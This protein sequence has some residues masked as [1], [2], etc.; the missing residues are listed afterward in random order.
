MAKGKHVTYH[1]GDY[2]IT[3]LEQ[4]ARYSIRVRRPPDDT[5]TKW[6]YSKSRRVEAKN[7]AEAVACCVKYAQELDGGM[8]DVP[9]TL[10]D[11]AKTF[12]ENREML[13]KVSPL[14]LAR[15]KI[16]IDRIVR[17]LGKRDLVDLSA[18]IIE[19]AYVEMTKDGVSKDAIH[20]CHMKLKQMMRKAYNTG[21]IK[22]NPCD[23]VEGITR[24]KQDPVKKKEK[25]ITRDEAIDLAHELENEEKTGKVV[26]V[27]LAL[28]TGIRRGEAL[29]LMWKDVDL[30][31]KRLHV[32]RQYGREKTLKPPKTEKSRR[33]IAIDTGT[34]SF[35]SKWKV[36]QATE[37]K[38]SLLQTGDTPVC[39]NELGGFTDPDDLS[40][41]RRG[42]YVRLGLA[43]YEKE[44]KWTDSRG[45][46]RVRHS[47]YVGPNFHALRHAQASLLVAG[48]VDPKTVQERL[49]H[50]RITTTLE[51]YADAEEENDVK[52]AEYINGLF[53]DR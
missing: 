4:G 47:G 12:Q 45:I 15:D 7:K 36:Q 19:K 50:E 11:Y 48:G 33:T 17:Y 16:N 22:R 34:V 29:G 28:A 2:E 20:K 5:H 41:W 10:A 38:R 18:T 27:R 51:I 39:S 3:V 37:L 6:H 21:L 26:A 1:E 30:E 49:G 32:R 24:P 42:F 8:S 35:L 46:E 52:A 25:R 23:A 9:I 31:N 13:G 14:T 53:E 43:H 40:R 44:E